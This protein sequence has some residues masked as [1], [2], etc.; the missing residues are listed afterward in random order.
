M[1]K[2]LAVV[3]AFFAVTLTLYATTNS[4]DTSNSLELSLKAY[5]IPAVIGQIIVLLADAKK[6]MIQ[7]H[8]STEIFVK[9]KLKVF[10]IT[11]AIALG[12]Y[13]ILFYL[14][15]AELLVKALTEAHLIEFI[16]VTM[17]AA[18]ASVI[19]GLTKSKPTLQ[20]NK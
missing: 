2:L 15:A 20:Q 1:K 4:I 9:T 16:S 13:I 5:F 12:Q 3:F 8:W 14:P 19:D 11:T 17:F 6:H 18:Y 10:G 7:G